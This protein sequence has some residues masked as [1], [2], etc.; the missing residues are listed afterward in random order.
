MRFD[1]LLRTGFPAVFAVITLAIG[2]NFLFL[3]QAQ[4]VMQQ[5]NRLQQLAMLNTERFSTTELE[6]L[7]ARYAS[8]NS[9]DDAAAARNA[10]SNLLK[11]LQNWPGDEYSR[12]VGHSRYIQDK[13]FHIRQS[14]SRVEPYLGTLDDP[15]SVGNS[16]IIL[17]GIGNSLAQIHQMVIE[18]AARQVEEARN[19]FQYSQIVQGVLVIAF[20]ATAFAWF[21]SGRARNTRLRLQAEA[22]RKEAETLLH[23]MNHDAVTGLMVHSAFAERV[24]EAHQTL[25]DDRTLSILCIDFDSRLPTLKTF[26]KA[27]EESIMAST[28]DLLRHA[29]DQLVGETCLARSTGKGFLLMIV[30]NREFGLTAAVIANRI[31]DL[32]LRPVQTGCGAFLVSPAIGYAEAATETDPADT[33]RNAELA[34]AS[35]VSSGRRRVVTYEPA[36]RA[37]MERRTTVELALAKAI[38]ANECLP[39]FQ[40]QFNLQTGRVFGLEALAR[41]YHSE[42]GW[43]SPSEFIPIA[44]SNG[45]IISLGWKILETSCSEI[46]LLPSDLSLS[47]NLSV[48]Q[49]LSDDVVAMLDECL[50]RTGLQA[51]RLK[52]EV[53]ETTVMSDFRRIEATLSELRALGVGISLDDFG[54]G[55]SA[56]SYLTDFHWDEIKIDRTFATKAVKDPKMREILKM[57]LGIAET[58]G[59][60]VLIEG[61]E[62][63]EQRDV[64]VDIGCT[65]G[66]GYLFGGP[67]AID[68]ITTLFFPDHGNRSLVGI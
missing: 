12:I 7:I 61:I 6:K 43:I 26:G 22:D 13:L 33:V 18:A 23:L 27:T 55:Y 30:S 38:E 3:L 52:L 62:T 67:M 51:T 16:L 59:S 2:L 40:P 21:L 50:S 5:K 10:Y 9:P 28:A 35:A 31:H 11:S 48:A 36:M 37:E 4:T 24:R 66:Q 25:A 64:L 57:V 34:V 41:W 63:V 49:I 8:L 39:H 47:V 42:L 1:K 46:Q 20:L 19:A 29:V 32:F 54:V 14:S 44:E 53:T 56:L 68:D 15:S 65:I 45:D 60:Q 58:M 17:Q